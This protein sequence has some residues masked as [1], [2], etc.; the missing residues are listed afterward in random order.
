MNFAEDKSKLG[1]IDKDYDH[2]NPKLANL[3]KENQELNDKINDPEIRRLYLEAYSRRKNIKFENI[4]KF[5]DG[6]DKNIVD[7]KQVI[8]TF[9]GTELGFMDISGVANQKVHWLKKGVR[10]K[11]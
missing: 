10:A 8:R 6:S 5:E 1:S 7:T 4:L 11:T 9:L 3:E 2:I